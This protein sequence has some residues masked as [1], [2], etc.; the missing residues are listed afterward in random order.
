LQ[1]RTQA[2][3]LRQRNNLFK[4]RNSEQTTEDQKKFR[5]FSFPKTSFSKSHS[6]NFLIIKL[7]ANFNYEHPIFI[8]SDFAFY[9]ECASSNY[10]LEF[11]SF[12]VMIRWT[13]LYKT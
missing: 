5:S 6:K 3:R 1:K 2:R 7:A 8:F 12:I 11:Q 9:W 10:L 4:K 13:K